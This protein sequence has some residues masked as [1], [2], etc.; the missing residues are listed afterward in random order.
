MKSL[1]TE[2]IKIDES[3]SSYLLYLTLKV[4]PTLLVYAKPCD[5]LAMCQLAFSP[6]HL[7]GKWFQLPCDPSDQTRLC[8]FS[9]KFNPAFLPIPESLKMLLSE[10]FSTHTACR[11]T[12]IRSSPMILGISVPDFHSSSKYLTPGMKWFSELLNRRSKWHRVILKR[13][14]TGTMPGWKCIH[15]SYRSMQGKC[16]TERRHRL[17]NAPYNET[18]TKVYP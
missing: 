4:N 10:K 2:L 7:L 9:R 16:L 12:G 18:T 8:T 5:W 17:L 15:L 1:A 13:Q 11:R 6:L 14:N 3:E